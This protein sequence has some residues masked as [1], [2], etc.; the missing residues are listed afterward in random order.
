MDLAQIE[1]LIKVLEG[2][3]TEE[4]AVQRGECTIRIR[5]R[6]KQEPSAAAPRV[7]VKPAGPPPIAKEEV[8][9]DS[10][11]RAPMVGIFHSIDGL[12][13]VGARVEEGQVVGSIES[14][15][16]LNDVIASMSGVVTEV[17]VDDGTPV[18]YGQPLCRIQLES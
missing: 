12:S 18:E 5:K 9:E 7:T 2:S 6:R 17:L 4:L 14:M 3:Q 13:K 11:I 8:P 15:K 1:E 10:I 16:L